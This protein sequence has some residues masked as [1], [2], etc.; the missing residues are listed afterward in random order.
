MTIQM[1]MTTIMQSPIRDIWKVVPTATNTSITTIEIE[2]NGDFRVVRW[3]DD[4]HLPAHLKDA[5]EKVAK[6]DDLLIN[7]KYNVTNAEV[8]HHFDGFANK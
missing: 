4:S 7:S 8:K 6:M 2:D 1:I 3:S 5:N